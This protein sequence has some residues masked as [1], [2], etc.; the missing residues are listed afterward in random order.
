MSARIQD[1][2]IEM[3][4]TPEVLA[5]VEQPFAD[6]GIEASGRTRESFTGIF[7]EVRM[8][9]STAGPYGGVDCAAMT[10]FR[11]II[12]HS[13]AAMIL[14]ANLERYD[15]ARLFGVAAFDAGVLERMDW[16]AFTRVPGF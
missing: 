6:L 1:V 7:T 13:P 2:T 14:F 15:K 4:L 3:L 16:R 10:D 8:F 5:A 9:G 11:L 12:V